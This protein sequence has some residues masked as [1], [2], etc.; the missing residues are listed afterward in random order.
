MP[1]DA[2]VQLLREMAVLVDK[3]DGI[4]GSAVLLEAAEHIL[5]LERQIKP[6]EPSR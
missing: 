5:Q 4:G 2:V 6:A 3:P 1:R